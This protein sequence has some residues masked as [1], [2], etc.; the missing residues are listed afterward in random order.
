VDGRP[1]A[2]RRSYA[3]PVA[4]P[5]DIES[6]LSAVER[7]VA[8]LRERTA[9]AG[10]DAAAARTL[11]AGADRDVSE[12]RA[13]L[14]AHTSALNALRQSQIEFG[15]QLD[16]FGGRL[17]GVDGRLDAQAHAMSA[18]FGS[19]EAGMAQVVTLLEGL[20]DRDE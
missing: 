13:E 10:S 8:E 15:Y 7:D 18:G 4:T 12:V 9:L 3:R 19:L 20:S 11:A 16:R 17:D 6:R 2:R 1:G 14:R 5:E